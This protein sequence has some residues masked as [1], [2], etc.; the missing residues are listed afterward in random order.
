M[1]LEYYSDVKEGKLQKNISQKIANELKHFEGK[2]VEIRI[3]KLKSTRSMQQNR[4]WWLAVTI[5]A[6]ELGYDK[7]EMH[8]ICKMKFLKLEKVCKITGEIFEYVGSTT[9]LSK[10]EF[11]DMVNDFVRWAAD[12]FNVIIPL[13]NEQL[14]IEL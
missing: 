8:E 1:K 12:T 2:R 14:D 13:P 11:A 7:N 6:N 10:S 5:L 4:Y 9:K 3:E